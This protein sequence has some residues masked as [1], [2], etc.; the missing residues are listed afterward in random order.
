MRIDKDHSR[1]QF[2]REKFLLGRIVS[3]N[4]RSKAEIALVRQLNRRRSRPAHEREA[5]PGRRPLR[6]KPALPR[7]ISASTVGG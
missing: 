7:G 2:R 1:L 5:P 6:D 3:P 4:T